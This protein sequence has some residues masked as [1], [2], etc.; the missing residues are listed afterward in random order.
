MSE[1]GQGDAAGVPESE[2]AGSHHQK[3]PL[4]LQVQR[5]RTPWGTRPSAGGE[6]LGVVPRTVPDGA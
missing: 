1:G 3:A 4:V 6:C 2:S 5:W